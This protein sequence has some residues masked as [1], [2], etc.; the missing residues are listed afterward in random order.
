[1]LKEKIREKVLQTFTITQKEQMIWHIKTKNGRRL[2]K[3][4]LFENRGAKELFECVELVMIEL[5]TKYIN[6]GKKTDKQEKRP[7]G[8]GV[9]RQK[10]LT[11]K[12]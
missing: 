4:K 5:E 3:I 10:A 7:T 2:E 6:M 11:I 1:M 9:L 8:Y 12:T